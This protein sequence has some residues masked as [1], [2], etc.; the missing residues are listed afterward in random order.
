MKVKR[1]KDK[2]NEIRHDRIEEIAKGELLGLFCIE[3][4]DNLGTP[5]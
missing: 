3:T 5:F 2:N 1:G 4:D